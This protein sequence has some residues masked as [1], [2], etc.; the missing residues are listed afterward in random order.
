MKRKV[1]ITGGS[2]GIGYATAKAFAKQGEEVLI[3]SRS[4]NKLQT[5]AKELNKE[6]G[7][8]CVSFF[9]AD[10][11]KQDELIQLAQFIYNQFGGCDILVNNAGLFIP[12]SI[13]NEEEG[14][15]QKM[16]ETNLYSAYHLTRLLLPKMKQNQSGDIVNICSIASITAYENGGS[17]AISKSALHSFSKNLREE[18]KTFG[19]RVMSVL[20]GAT[21]TDSWAGVE[22]E[23]QRFMPADDIASSILNACNISRRSV[24]EEII[25]RPQLGDL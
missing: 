17:Y 1:V 7:K 10:C 14:S 2:R 3:V 11:S 13:Q 24:V 25:I 23:E 5:A 18:L 4:E 20:P 8:E 16:I 12:G 22:I 9:N 6:V 15:L 21:F 19:I